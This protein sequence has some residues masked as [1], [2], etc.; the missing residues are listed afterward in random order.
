MILNNPT[1]AQLVERRTV[2]VSTDKSLV[3]LSFAFSGVGVLE[4]RRHCTNN[5]LLSP[6]HC[7]IQP[8]FFIQLSIWVVV[9]YRLN[10]NEIVANEVYSFYLAMSDIAYFLSEIVDADATTLRLYLTCIRNT[11]EAAMCLQECDVTERI[12]CNCFLKT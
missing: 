9:I 10:N 4:F 2:V 6:V 8:V 12:A 3:F 7:T 1:L 11:L 5:F